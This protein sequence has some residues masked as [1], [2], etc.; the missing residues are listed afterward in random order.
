MWW[1][2]RKR[3]NSPTEDADLREKPLVVPPETPPPAKPVQSNLYATPNQRP[4]PRRRAGR[5]VP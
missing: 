4:V 1:F 2:F 5:R 3:R